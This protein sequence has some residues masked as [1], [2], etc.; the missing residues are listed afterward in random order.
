MAKDEKKKKKKKK[1]KK[2]GNGRD[3][4]ILGRSWIFNQQVM[5]DIHIKSELGRYR[6]R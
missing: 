4:T 3:T 6:M 2:N 5:D 1:S